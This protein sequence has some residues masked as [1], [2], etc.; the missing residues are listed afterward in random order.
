MDGTGKRQGLSQV[1]ALHHDATDRPN[2]VN[3]VLAL[4]IFLKWPAA[5]VLASRNDRGQE[6]GGLGIVDVKS[7][8]VKLE[9]V[10]SKL[11]QG[12]GDWV[13][14]AGQVKVE[15]LARQLVFLQNLFTLLKI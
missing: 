8:H 3:L 10:K 6:R 1:V 14:A 12:I 5:Q 13:R 11:D 9:E 15:E 7:R 4:D 2:E